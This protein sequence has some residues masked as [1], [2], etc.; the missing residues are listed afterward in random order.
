MFVTVTVGV[1]VGVAVIVAVGYGV[2]V[3]VGGIGVSVD[4]RNPKGDTVWQALKATRR[5]KLNAINALVRR[6]MPHPLFKVGI[7]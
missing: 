4:F 2:A 3:E 5:I 1:M 6:A 7:L